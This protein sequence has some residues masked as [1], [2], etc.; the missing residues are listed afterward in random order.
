M[1]LEDSLPHKLP[2]PYACVTASSQGGT[3]VMLTLL[4]A[5]KLK[6]EITSSGKFH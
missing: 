3:T 6:S 2:R 5:G 4:T 1:S